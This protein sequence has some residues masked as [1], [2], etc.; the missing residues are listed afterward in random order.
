MTTLRGSY[1]PV[2]S[3]TIHASIAHGNECDE[4]VVTILWFRERNFTGNHGSPHRTQRINVTALADA[5]RHRSFDGWGY[6]PLDEIDR[7]NVGQLRMAGRA[8]SGRGCSRGR[9]AA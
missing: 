8:A 5:G 3:S 4:A 2:R 1:R 9:S 7:D 6:S